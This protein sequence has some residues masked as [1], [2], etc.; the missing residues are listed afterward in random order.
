MAS[1]ATKLGLQPG[2]MVCLLD[3]PDAAVELLRAEAPAGVDIV[4]GEHDERYDLLF[5]WPQTLDGLAERFAALQW[6]IMPDGALWVVIPKKAFARKRGIAF[7]WEEM[8]VAALTTDLVDN[9]IA[10]FTEEDYA[11]R[12]VIRKER[13]NAYQ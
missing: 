11:T 10:S 6:R 3:A 5:F 12:F 1:L 7:T 8:Q 9:K 2:Q 13:R 4:R